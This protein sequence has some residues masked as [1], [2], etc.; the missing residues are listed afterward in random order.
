[1]QI[2]RIDS[3]A[4]RSWAQ[5]FVPAAVREAVLA[6][7]TAAAAAAAAAAAVGAASAAADPAVYDFMANRVTKF[8]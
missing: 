2:R 1:M 7:V 6:H 5:R 4:A 8:W 3:T